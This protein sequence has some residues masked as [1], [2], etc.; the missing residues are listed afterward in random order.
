MAQRLTDPPYL[1]FPLRVNG[2]PKLAT[3]A[4]HIRGQIE[5]VLYTLSGERVF[6]P[7]F[8]AGVKAL[9]FEPNASAL[10]QV[11]EKR[12][13]ASLIESLAGEVEPKSIKVTV[14]GNNEQLTITIAYVLAAIGFEDQHQFT[15]SA[16]S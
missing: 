10:W 3:R 13:S 5:Q 12:I 8:G 16:G 2:G 1:K 14:A 7:E 6:R 9:V 15:F 4:E 11:T